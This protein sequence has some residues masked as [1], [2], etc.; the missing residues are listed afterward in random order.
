MC[1]IIYY[2]LMSM[3]CYLDY[4]CLGGAVVRGLNFNVTAA[5]GVTL[6]LEI[7]TLEM[8]CIFLFRL[9]FDF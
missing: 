4:N 5:P 1:E 9:C 8:F 3:S 6:K 7:S 2:Y